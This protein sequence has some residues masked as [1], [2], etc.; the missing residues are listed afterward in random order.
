MK[1]NLV[2]TILAL[3]TLLPVN[4]VEK[5]VDCGSKVKI[6]ATPKEG[7]VFLHW[8]DDVTNTNPERIFENVQAAI[9]IQAIFGKQVTIAISAEEGGVVST[10]GGTYMLGDKIEVE[11]TVTDDCYE[12]IGWS[13][14]ETNAKRTI[15]V[16]NETATNIVAKFKL[17]TFKLIVTSDNDDWG[18]VQISAVTE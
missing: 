6:T 9:E 12:F 10:T 18:T 7:Y 11:A 15:T 8:S 4:A 1:K 5:T 13:D 16:T 2:L 14:G 3:C 17:K